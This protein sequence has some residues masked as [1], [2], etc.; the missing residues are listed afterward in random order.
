[1]REK[2]GD[3]SRKRGIYKVGCL[4]E[5][6]KR[7]CDPEKIRISGSAVAVE[8]LAWGGRRSQAA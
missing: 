3:G 2:E 6:A 7:L 8:A 1:M 4:E 5:G